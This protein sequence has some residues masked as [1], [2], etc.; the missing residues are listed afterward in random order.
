MRSLRDTLVNTFF[1]SL[2]SSVPDIYTTAQ[3]SLE[4]IM[5]HTRLPK[6]TLQV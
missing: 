1:R 6:E 5:R 2:T 3:S 4:C